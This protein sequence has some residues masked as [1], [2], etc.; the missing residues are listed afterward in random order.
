M[1]SKD[2]GGSR[3]GPSGSGTQAPYGSPQRFM[4]A[5]QAFLQQSAAVQG[6]AASHPAFPGATSDS[7]MALQMMSMFSPLG[8]PYMSMFAP[9]SSAEIQEA[10]MAGDSQK[11]T[12]LMSES[13]AAMQAYQLAAYAGM[14]SS[15]GMPMMMSPPAP[16]QSQTDTG[17]KTQS[18]KKKSSS[19]SS[20]SSSKESSGIP[21]TSSGNN[22][23]SVAIPSSTP[24]P[25]TLTSPKP[26]RTSPQLSSPG[27]DLRAKSKPSPGSSAQ[28]L[29]IQAPI[30]PGKDGPLSPRLM[31]PRLKS[32][33]S[34]LGMLDKIAQKLQAKAE[35][36][37]AAESSSST[38]NSSVISNEKPEETPSIPNETTKSHPAQCDKDSPLPSAATVLPSLSP[39]V[40]SIEPELHTKADMACPKDVS[41]VTKKSET[42][43]S[44]E[45][46]SSFSTTSSKS[47]IVSHTK[48]PSDT[49]ELSSGQVEKL[50]VS[51][52]PDVTSDHTLESLAPSTQA[53]D[54]T[55]NKHPEEH[56]KP[57]SDD[58]AAIVEPTSCL[59]P[60]AVSTEGVIEDPVS[61]LGMKGKARKGRGKKKRGRPC[62]NLTAA[63]VKNE[64][65]LPVMS[66]AVPNDK[67]ADEVLQSAEVTP[68]SGEAL[69]K[70]TKG[71]IKKRVRK[72]RH[73]PENVTPR[74]LRPNRCM[75]AEHPPPRPVTPSDE[76]S[77]KEEE[78]QESEVTP[79]DAPDDGKE[80]VGSESGS[81]P[82]E[83]EQVNKPSP[84]VISQS[85]GGVSALLAGL[86][87]QGQIDPSESSDLDPKYAL[88]P[89]GD[90][91]SAAPSTCSLDSSPDKAVDFSRSLALDLLESL[92]GP[93]KECEPCRNQ[94]GPCEDEHGHCAQKMSEG[95]SDKV[96]FLL[97]FFFYF[98]TPI[99]RWNILWY[100]TVCLSVCALVCPLCMQNL[101]I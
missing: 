44:D 10:I 8:S 87:S 95:N 16:T 63:K 7:A 50:P 17:R 14:A 62:A 59:T 24:K 27:L 79:A 33:K 3:G 6:A 30:T 66:Q 85:R 65:P 36:K 56:S 28:S 101:K 49:S 20:S 55:K 9:G 35:A 74:V 45:Q 18:S 5:Y 98:Y 57:S 96:R 84:K 67:P 83:E 4:E 60:E 43:V 64:D 80:D 81:K 41:Q 69:K 100:G 58:S 40:A 76:E 86:G 93:E 48:G 77:E 82:E 38:T 51:A 88:D 90:K 78:E 22:A 54:E 26:S 32:P 19:S 73:I 94:S 1:A 25:V 2:P 31:S 21:G 23:I 39:K 61:G 97:L 70:S 71:P 29:T 34:G 47:D 11:A 52:D 15:Y 68:P 89:D 91:L 53:L 37:G 46:L 72:K 13:M 12:Q 92:T 99:F 42:I 75:R